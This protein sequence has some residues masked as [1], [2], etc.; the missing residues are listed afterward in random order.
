MQKDGGTKSK[1]STWLPVCWVL[2]L[3]E[4]TFL[5]RLVV[6]IMVTAQ[7]FC[8]NETHKRICHACW[9]LV[10]SQWLFFPSFLP[11]LSFITKCPPYS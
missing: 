8:E 7:G 4:L 2:C 11:F 5:F 3:G 1:A 10:G 9:Q 6:V